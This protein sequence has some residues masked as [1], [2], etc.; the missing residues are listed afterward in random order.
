V[1]AP[2]FTG[3]ISPSTE[4][5]TRY[6]YYVNK[7]YREPA[8]ILDSSVTQRGQEPILGPEFSYK[9]LNGMPKWSEL[10]FSAHNVQFQLSHTFN[11]HLTARFAGVFRRFDES[12]LSPSARMANRYNPYTGAATPEQTWAL[13]DPSLRHDALLNPYIPTDSPYYD[14]TAIPLIGQRI[15]EFWNE[16]YELQN[17]WVLKYDFPY[18]SLQSVAGIAYSHSLAVDKR[19]HGS[20]SPINLFDLAN[21]DDTPTWDTAL[22]RSLRTEGTNWQI[23]INQ[24]LSFWKNRIALTGGCL[25]YNTE[26]RS[27][28]KA[29]ANLE[30][31]LDASKDLYVASALVRITPSAS[32]YY[33]YSIN[34]SPFAANF[35][36]L[37]REGKQHEWG[38]KM[39]FFNRR[40]A[41]NLSYFKISLTNGEIWNLEYAAG[42][43][44]QPGAFVMD[45]NNHGTEFEVSGALTKNLSILGSFTSLSMRAPYG[46][47]VNSISERLLSVL[48]NYRFHEGSLKGLG[49]SAGFHYVG[50]MAGDTPQVDFT[51]LGI[52][53]QNSYFIPSH[54]TWN[55]G[56][57][58]AWDCYELRLIVDN[59]TDD[60]NYIA[61]AGG[62]FSQHGLAVATGRNIRLAATVKF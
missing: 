4:L 37:W 41:V 43:L 36:V 26:T 15:I 34:A 17:D 13:K 21:Y 2:Q 53:T 46:R 35:Q 61:G 8:L 52:L 19:V 42:D 25:K 44:T 56:A 32:F 10:W 30:D 55:A 54:T 51:P 6:H 16:N 12:F 18:V 1:I 39:E 24:R 58:Y 29:T 9:G 33:S 14:P 23:Y 31:V 62:R 28:D 38:A 20:I 3:R 57:T 48:L 47:Y 45:F 5:V 50:E 60:K 11:E 59:L 40:L 49:V 7:A 22:A 27:I